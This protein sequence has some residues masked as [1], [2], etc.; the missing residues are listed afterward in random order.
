MTAIRETTG[1]T[2]GTR[3]VMVC[4]KV[5]GKKAKVCKPAVVKA[6]A[7]KAGAKHTASGKGKHKAG[8]GK[9][10]AASGKKAKPKKRST[11]Q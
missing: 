3:T 8:K 1:E 2:G 9:A 4:R 10:A 6:K 11:T 5:K 7:L